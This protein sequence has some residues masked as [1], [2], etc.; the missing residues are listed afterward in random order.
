M[1]RFSSLMLLA[2]AAACASSSQIP[3]VPHTAAAPIG[4]IPAA[5]LPTPAVGD[6]AP[7]FSFIPITRTGSAVKRQKLSDYRGQT[8]VLWTF[9]KARTRG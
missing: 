2:A 8:V 9:V 6:M 7:D 1:T 4:A 3:A 5:A